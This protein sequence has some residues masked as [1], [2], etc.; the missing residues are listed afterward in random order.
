MRKAPSGSK[1]MAKEK[2]NSVFW[3]IVAILAFLWLLGLV[4]SHVTGGQVPPA[5]GRPYRG[6]PRDR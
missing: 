5:D 4:S 1:F 3:M 2:E 6:A